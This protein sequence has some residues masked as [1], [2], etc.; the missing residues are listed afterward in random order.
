M[1]P[2]LGKRRIPPAC[3]RDTFSL[4]SHFVTLRRVCAPRDSASWW[5]ARADGQQTHLAQ[6]Q[7]CSFH[8]QRLQN[9]GLTFYPPIAK[10]YKSTASERCV[11]SF[12]GPCPGLEK[13]NDARCL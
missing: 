12:Q 3:T 11:P 9:H 7:P 4:A 13:C 2:S 6:D 5:R 10:C 1:L 8:F